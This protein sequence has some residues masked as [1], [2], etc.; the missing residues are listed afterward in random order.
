MDLRLELADRGHVLLGM[1]AEERRKRVSRWNPIL[2]MPV[3]VR[4][5]TKGGTSA[6]C[7][8]KK[9]AEERAARTIVFHT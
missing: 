7:G 8:P 6:F 2:R 4:L 1:C 3:N 9:R 5:D